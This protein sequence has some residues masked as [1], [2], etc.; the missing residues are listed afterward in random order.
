MCWGREEEKEGG[1]EGKDRDEREKRVVGREVL[2][3]SQ[4]SGSYC[5]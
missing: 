2:L 5:L 4:R 1:R 3:V